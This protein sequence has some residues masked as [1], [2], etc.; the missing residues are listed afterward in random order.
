MTS[1]ENK[2]LACGGFGKIMAPDGNREKHKDDGGT[3]VTIGSSRRPE[4]DRNGGTTVMA[5]D[6]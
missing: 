4:S 6:G 5:G 1:A 2:A 3:G